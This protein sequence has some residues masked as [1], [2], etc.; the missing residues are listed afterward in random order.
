M[1]TLTYYVA[2]LGLLAFAPVALADRASAT[3]AVAEARVLIRS[4]ERGGADALAA[5]EFRLAREHYNTAQVLLEDR[6]WLEAEYAAQKA[7][8]DAEVAVA[9]TQALKAEQALAE[10]E[11]VVNS[12]RNEIQRQA[13]MQ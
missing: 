8:R 12:L 1:K 6:D 3:S 7:Q 5:T 4:A 13:D 9:K 10:L 2:A 11:V